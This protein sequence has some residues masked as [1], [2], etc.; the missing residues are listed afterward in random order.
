MGMVDVG[1]KMD[2]EREA[3][4]VGVVKL[5]EGTIKAIREG[6]IP[7]GDVV[8]AAKIA[9]ITAVKNTPQLLP[10]CH[11]LIINGVDADVRIG[12][13]EVKV[14]VRVK[15][16]ART[17][18]EM[19]ALCGVTA[20]L[21]CV[22]DMVKSFEKDKEGQYPE[23]EIYGVRVL[24]KRKGGPPSHHLERATY[25]VGYITV[26]SS[27]GEG[28]DSCGDMA[29]MLISS[30]GH[31]VRRYF[32]PDEKN[33]IRKTLQEALKECDTVILSGG[34]GIT[35]D[36]VTLEAVRGLFEKEVGGFGA[37]FT[38]MSAEQVGT[39]AALSSATAGLVGNKVVFCLPGNPLAVRL[40][41]RRLILPE[42]N[43]WVRLAR[44]YKH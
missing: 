40:A 4:A 7:K 11:P 1:D 2:V 28:E 42:I 17:G 26:S 16:V 6:R 23:T 15:T 10:F 21:L 3:V 44:G 37:L 34:T 36:D 24:E 30:A 5:R 19:E 39:A 32:A 25:I 29:E 35:P 43:H 27:R 22:W 38:Q 31:K 13:E 33:T 8:E 41:L 14:E 12:E 9:A 20:A 18:V